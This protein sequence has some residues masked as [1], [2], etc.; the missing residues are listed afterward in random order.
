[1]RRKYV[2]HLP[3]GGV[4]GLR[5]N[6]RDCAFNI[7]GR[8]RYKVWMLGMLEQIFRVNVAFQKI[9]RN[10]I[11][12]NATIGANTFKGGLKLLD[13]PELGFKVEKVTS[14]GRLFR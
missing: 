5:F 8:M 2:V 3:D 9:G 7:G 4:V 1:M 11:R 6:P 14:L 10:K 13:I 12:G